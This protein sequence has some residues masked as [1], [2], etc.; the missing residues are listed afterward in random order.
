MSDQPDLAD[1]ARLARTE[2]LVASDF[3][4]EVVILSI[5]SG[6]F[7]HLNATGTRIWSLLD[8]PITLAALCA[9]MRE[10]FAV[11]ADEC[12]RSVTEFVQGMLERGLLERA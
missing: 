8:T 11:D 1:D 10:R 9:A 3:N 12:R 5:E 2:G 7:F 4:G 6:H